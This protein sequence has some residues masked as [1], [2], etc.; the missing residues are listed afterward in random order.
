M[1]V[2]SLIL[3]VKSRLEQSK[4]VA[5]DKARTKFENYKHEVSKIEEEY[6]SHFKS[7]RFNIFFKYKYKYISQ[8][9]EIDAFL[10]VHTN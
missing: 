3:M 1:E 5:F 6:Q 9:K 10:D 7:K 2:E 4:S 8:L